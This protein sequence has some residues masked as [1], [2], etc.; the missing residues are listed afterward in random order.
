M[1]VLIV[2]IETVGS[3]EIEIEPT[4][5]IITISVPFLLKYGVLLG[6]DLAY[7]CHLFWE[8]RLVKH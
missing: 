3:V 2:I 8:T 7:V 5:S 1:S 6:G 4:V